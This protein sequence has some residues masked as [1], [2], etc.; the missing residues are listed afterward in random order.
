MWSCI[1]NQNAL[2]TTTDIERYVHALIGDKRLSSVTGRTWT[3]RVG[4]ETNIISFQSN[5]F[6]FF[7][8]YAHYRYTRQTSKVGGAI[9]V[10]QV[11][12]LEFVE[13]K[14]LADTHISSKLPSWDLS[15]GLPSPK[16]LSH[17]PAR[18]GEKVEEGPR[19]QMPCEGIQKIQREAGVSLKPSLT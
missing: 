12:K 7:H 13:D 4:E 11:R 18:V 16:V 9:C 14:G 10:L 1:E 5:T 6:F 2:L 19:T 15:P 3:W 17:T 8:L